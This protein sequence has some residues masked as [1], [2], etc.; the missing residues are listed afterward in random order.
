MDEETAIIASQGQET[1]KDIVYD[2]P[3]GL[4]SPEDAKD[5]KELKRTL[6]LDPETVRELNANPE[7][8][9]KLKEGSLALPQFEEIMM[10]IEPL[11]HHH[12]HH[13]EEKEAAVITAEATEPLPPPPEPVAVAER[14]SSA[15]PVIDFA[16]LA[17]VAAA[18]SKEPQGLAEPIPNDRPLE[19]EFRDEIAD[20]MKDPGFAE[21]MKAFGKQ[22]ETMGLKAGNGDSLMVPDETPIV[23]QEKATAMAMTGR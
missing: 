18:M 16:A 8:L 15:L 5:L 9:E 22:M 7:L 13:K 12:K 10:G 6:E 19:L 2:V 1:P 20:R 23:V 21:M 3:P 4:Q 14:E 11:H 17:S